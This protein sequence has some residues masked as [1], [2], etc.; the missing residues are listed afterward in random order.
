M[1]GFI[2]F[3]VGGS[4]WRRVYQNMPDDLTLGSLELLGFRVMTFIRDLKR[5]WS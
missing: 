1:E 2:A 3:R 4:Q 5:R